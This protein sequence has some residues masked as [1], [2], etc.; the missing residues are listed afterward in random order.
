M[1]ATASVTSSIAI[2]EK[3]NQAT[4][5]ALARANECQDADGREVHVKKIR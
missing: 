1:N 5:A 2:V 4:K 3:K